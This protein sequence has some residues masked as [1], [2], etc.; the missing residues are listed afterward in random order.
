MAIEGEIYPTYLQ[1]QSSNVFVLVDSFRTFSNNNDMIGAITAG[2]EHG[3]S[4]VAF[5]SIQNSTQDQA[6]RLP[7]VYL[8]ILFAI[9]D[10][11]ISQLR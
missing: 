8:Q 5:A 10:D 2:S 4:Q 7:D 11:K 9:F 3:T 6:Y 1:R